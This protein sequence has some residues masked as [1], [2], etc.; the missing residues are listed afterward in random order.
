MDVFDPSDLESWDEMS[1]FEEEEG[2]NILLK[3]VYRVIWRLHVHT[4]FAIGPHQKKEI[5]RFRNGKEMC[6][7]FKSKEIWRR[8]Q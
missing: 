7:K 2:V 6:I 1:D 8:L 5:R 4:L 3:Y